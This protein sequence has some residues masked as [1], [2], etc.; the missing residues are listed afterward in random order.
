LRIAPCKRGFPTCLACFSSAVVEA[1]ALLIHDISPMQ[2][3]EQPEVDTSSQKR[4][5]IAPSLT[6]GLDEFGIIVIISSTHR[7]AMN[8]RE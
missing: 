6:S 5:F 1:H 8:C 4:L 7:S 2:I 3:F